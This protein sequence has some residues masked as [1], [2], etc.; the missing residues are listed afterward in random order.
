MFKNLSLE[1]LGISGSQSEIIELALSFGFKGLDLNLIEFSR[2]V[3]EYGLPK[4]RRLV[5]SAKL[6]LGTF[7]LPVDWYA[8]DADYRLA[9]Q[10]LPALLDLA[11][12]VGC[13]RATTEVQPA[14][15]VRPYHQ[16]FE[17]H[18][19]RLSEICK[20]LEGYSV[21][22][23]L[24][25]QACNTQRQGK[26]FE[27]IHDLDTLVI[28]LGTVGA[29]NLGL[30]LDLWQLHACGASFAAARKKLKPNQI[31]AVSVADAPAKEPVTDLTPSERLL[32]GETGVI[33]T[34]GVLAALAELDY[35][36]PVT[37]V[38]HPSRFT[39]VRR[40]QVIKQVGEKLDA[41]WKA[42]GISTGGRVAA[43]A[44]R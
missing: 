16:N 28:L 26:A 38:A 35:D 1:S 29:K 2:E 8:E 5:D 3:Q 11:S 32:P 19:Q 21:R 40:D 33:D 30:H 25:F 14:S 37:P 9:M 13:T 31:V 34:S 23:A 6:K 27:F 20:V 18:R 17:F 4:A 10:K 39:G 7:R 22:L 43:A 36:G 42:A 24:G 44:G 12:Q 41:C 15:D